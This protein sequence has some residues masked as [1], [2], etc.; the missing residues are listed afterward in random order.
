MNAPSD[1]LIILF[2]RSAPGLFAFLVA[3]LP[4]LLAL[5]VA[6]ALSFFP[7]D[8]PSRLALITASLPT[9]F[10]A[11]ITWTTGWFRWRFAI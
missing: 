8:R 1:T 9:F 5:C 6:V 7:A 2:L 3:D 4:V 11:L 10:L